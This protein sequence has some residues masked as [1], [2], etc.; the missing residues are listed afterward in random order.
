MIVTH[1][2]LFNIIVALFIAF[3]SGWMVFALVSRRAA[4]LKSKMDQLER[5]KDDLRRHAEQLEEQLQ[6][7]YAF[8]SATIISLSS[9]VKS[10]KAKDGSV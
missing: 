1:P 8:N 7:P 9:S 10:T 3:T 6:K 4:D 2:L 5:E